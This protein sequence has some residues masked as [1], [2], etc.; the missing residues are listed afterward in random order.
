MYFL[1]GYVGVGL[2]GLAMFGVA[3]GAGYFAYQLD[4]MAVVAILLAAALVYPSCRYYVSISTTNDYD[5][6]NMFIQ[7]ITLKAAF[8]GIFLVIYYASNLY[9]YV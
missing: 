9:S 2:L 5:F 8:M 4:G 3:N 6:T 7:C 1:V